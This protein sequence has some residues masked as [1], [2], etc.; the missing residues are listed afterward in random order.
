MDFNKSANDIKI[1]VPEN[2]T[3]PLDSAKC[4]NNKFMLVVYNHDVCDV[5][6]LHNLEDGKFLKNIELPPLP[7]IALSVK[8]DQDEFFFKYISFLSPGTIYHFSF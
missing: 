3:D 2:K 5:L 6:Q 1:V 7:T 8:H 4:V